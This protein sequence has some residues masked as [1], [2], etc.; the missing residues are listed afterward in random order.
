VPYR[1]D[2]VSPVCNTHHST[3]LHHPFRWARDRAG[4]E[5]AFF[6]NICAVLS[7]TYSKKPLVRFGGARIDFLAFQPSHG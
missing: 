7:V 2:D 3:A 6:K 4:L 1:M 5:Y